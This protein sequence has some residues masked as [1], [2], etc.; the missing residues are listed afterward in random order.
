MIWGGIDSFEFYLFFEHSKAKFKC[1]S[2]HKFS[3]FNYN[4]SFF[5][6]LHFSFLFF[7]C[8]IAS[9]I[10]SD[11]LS[12]RNTQCPQQREQNRIKRKACG[13]DKEKGKHQKE[14]QGPK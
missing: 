10:V 5:F 6:L 11:I 2:F 13:C 3:V 9:L 8:F 14:N 1:F 12:P 7:F 4:F